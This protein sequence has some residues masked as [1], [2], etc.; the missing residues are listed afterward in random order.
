MA[1]SILLDSSIAIPHLR[2]RFNILSHISAADLLFISLIVLGELYKGVFKAPRPDESRR[3][4]DAF[5]TNVSVL[6]LDSA[7]S[8]QYARLASVLERQGTLIPENDIW[9]A[10]TALE[11]DM[12]LVTRDAHFGQ[13]PGLQVLRW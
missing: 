2:G 12:P 5:L 8:I 13:V 11:C 10:A 9:I 3:K 6:G 4:L 1:R 7:T